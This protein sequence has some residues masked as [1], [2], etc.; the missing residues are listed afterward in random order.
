MYIKVDHYVI[1][2]L[3]RDLTGHDKRPATF[4]VYLFLW[5]RT[6]GADLRT[7][8]VS[9]QQIATATGL[10]KRA[11]QDSIR[12]LAKR[13]LLKVQK[14]SRTAVPQYTLHRPWRRGSSA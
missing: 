14:A 6:L 9:H 5:Y 11:V 4:I 13:R 12:L 10:S 1:D 3:M 7:V 2:V 8:R